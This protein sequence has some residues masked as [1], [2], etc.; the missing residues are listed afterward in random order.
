MRNF[1]VISPHFPETYYRFAQALKNNGFRV[2][3]VGD[4]SFFELPHELRNCLDEY[5]CCY[6]MDN[7]EN[8]KHA[9]GHFRN[10]YGIIDYVESNNEYW[11]ERD[12]WLR[13]ILIFQM[14]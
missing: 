4:A 8:E 5:Y 10:K 12:S 14:V 11:L 7:Y 2:L 1:I 6:D 3:G 9:V 13:M